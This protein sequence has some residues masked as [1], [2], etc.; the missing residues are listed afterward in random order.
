MN[1]FCPDGF[2]VTG[3]GKVSFGSSKTED[4]DDITFAQFA[5]PDPV[6]GSVSHAVKCTRQLT[7]GE[8]L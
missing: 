1:C 8:L 6:R 2:T 3:N 4:V 7:T 5:I